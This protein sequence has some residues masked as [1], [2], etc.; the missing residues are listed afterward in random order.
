MFR[1]IYIVL[2]LPI[3]LAEYCVAQSFV[4]GTNYTCPPLGKKKTYQFMQ[5]SDSLSVNSFYLNDQ[6]LKTNIEMAIN[7]AFRELGFQ[8]RGYDPQ[9]LV[10]YQVLNAPARLNGSNIFLKNTEVDYTISAP[11]NVDPGTLIISF[12]DAADGRMLWQGF[13]SGFIDSQAAEKNTVLINDA[14]RLVMKEYAALLS[15]ITAQ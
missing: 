13:A 6:R 11:F 3:I 5:V 14:V 15:S 1:L 2:T 9:L 7:T 10:K 4:V 12:M 8:N